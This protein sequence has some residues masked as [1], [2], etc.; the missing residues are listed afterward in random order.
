MIEVLKS[1]LRYD[2]HLVE[3]LKVWERCAYPQL[4]HSSVQVALLTMRSVPVISQ[5]PS[6]C[7]QWQ[8]KNYARK[9]LPLWPRTGWTV[10]P[11][12]RWRPSG[13][14]PWHWLLTDRPIRSE[15]KDVVDQVT[16]P[17]TSSLRPPIWVRIL[18]KCSWYFLNTGCAH[19]F[20][21]GVHGANIRGHAQLSWAS[22]IRPTRWVSWRT[23]EDPHAC[24]HHGEL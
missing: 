19:L 7:S 5:S 20:C 16:D 9:W 23:L 22:S 4:R 11:G 15:R 18:S 1:R 10:G 21:G 8:T 3:I 12:K 24:I 2:G 17:R 14:C 6:D 13:S